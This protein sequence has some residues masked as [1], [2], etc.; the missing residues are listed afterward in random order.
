MEGNEGWKRQSNRI[1]GKETEGVDV[2]D[3]ETEEGT[4]L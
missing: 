2:K 1:Q 4:K 3:E